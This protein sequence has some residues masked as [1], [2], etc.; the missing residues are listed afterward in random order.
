MATY[1]Y[2]CYDLLETFKQTFDDKEISITQVLFWVQI[3]ENRL[4]SQHIKK[5]FKNNSVGKYLCVFPEVEV[6]KSA[7]DGENLTK[8][9]YYIDLPAEIYE[10][11]NESGIEYI[12]HCASDD[13]C[14]DG[15]PAGQILFQPTIP[16]KLP[17]LYGDPYMKPAP[18]NPYFYRTKNRLWLVGFE[19]VDLSCVEMGLYVSINPEETCDLDTQI[20][21]D[22]ELI[23]VLKYEVLN[24]GRWSLM[25]PN[26]RIN[27]G[28]DNTTQAIN[29]TKI[30][31]PE[32]KSNS[33]SDY[34]EDLSSSQS[35]PQ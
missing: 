3:I 1:R 6:Q 20:E 11:P 24:L 9:R 14:C 16:S 8:N 27:E 10:F 5:N 17:V 19:C 34:L 30:E 23:S 29:Q 7:V 2:V 13:L 35:N 22:D 26:E 32:I 33:L 31:I 28:S 18:D 21:L 25:I 4:K 15:L 12:T